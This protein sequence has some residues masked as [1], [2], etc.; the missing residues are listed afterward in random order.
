M[1]YYVN[2]LGIITL[3]YSML[4]NNYTLQD[5]LHGNKPKQYGDMFLTKTGIITSGNWKT[6]ATHRG[7]T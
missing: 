7:N 6:P 4:L 3:T 1:E 5:C 2:F